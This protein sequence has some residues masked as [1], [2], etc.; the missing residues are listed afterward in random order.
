MQVRAVGLNF[1]D[2]LNVLGEYPGEPGPPGGDCSGVVITL[3]PTVGG[4]SWASESL[5]MLGRLSRPL[6]VLNRL[7]C[8]CG[9][10]ITF[11]GAATLLLFGALSMWQADEP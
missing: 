5:A 6:L 10:S 7:C 9:V 2:V 8:K 1:R 3:V 11:E 4:F